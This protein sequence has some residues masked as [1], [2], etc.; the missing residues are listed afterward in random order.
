MVS[1]WP[2]C[3]PALQ[4]SLEGTQSIHGGLLQAQ[5]LQ[6]WGTG[7]D[8]FRPWVTTCA[9]VSYL[10]FSLGKHGCGLISSRKAEGM[11]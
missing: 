2:C 11:A 6:K 9:E 1:L 7:M 3:V 4:H 8:E 10:G 5:F